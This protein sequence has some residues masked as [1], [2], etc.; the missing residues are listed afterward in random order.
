MKI[1]GK[2]IVF[3]RLFVNIFLFL[4][5]YKAKTPKNRILSVVRLQKKNPRH[6]KSKNIVHFI[7]ICGLMTYKKGPPRQS[8][9][10]KDNLNF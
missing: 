6:Q 5:E 9:G 10:G 4:H 7:N 8:R 1:L 3:A 2:S